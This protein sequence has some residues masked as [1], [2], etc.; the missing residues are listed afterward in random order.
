M[1]GLEDGLDSGEKGEIGE[2]LEESLDNGT[3]RHP[4]LWLGET[5]HRALPT[6]CMGNALI[7]LCLV[8]SDQ[9][10]DG[11]PPNRKAQQLLA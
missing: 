4:L 9:G 8:N 3:C 2:P 6:G 10:I 11:A 5:R 1:D 7:E